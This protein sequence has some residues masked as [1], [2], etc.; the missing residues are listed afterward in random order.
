MRD[1]SASSWLRQGS[2]I[3]CDRAKLGPLIT[4]GCLISLREA[5]SWLRAWP[6]APRNNGDTVLVGGLETC[7]DLL[8]AQDAEAFIR[9]D[10]RK[11]ILEFQ[12]RWDRRGLVF[13]F[14]TSAKL[15]HRATDDEIL[16][17]HGGK[18]IRLSHTLW[19]GTTTIDIAR[20]VADDGSGTTLGYHVRRVS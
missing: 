6:N 4:S 3:V 19:N 20:L 12:S 18:E 2:S 15:H 13:G 14:S 16:F 7:L 9:G 10:I 5:L 1:M 17:K 8:S 11:L